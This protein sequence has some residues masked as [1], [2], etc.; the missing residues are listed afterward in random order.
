MKTSAG[1]LRTMY[2]NMAPYGKW[3]V[4]MKVLKKVTGCIVSFKYSETLYLR[5]PSYKDINF[6]LQNQINQFKYFV[7]GFI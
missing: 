4:M 1:I 3:T 2:T 5:H 7:Q 6:W